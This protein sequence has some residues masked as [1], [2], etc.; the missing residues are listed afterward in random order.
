M[1]RSFG[2]NQQSTVVVVEVVLANCIEINGIVTNINQHFHF[3][4]PICTNHEIFENAMPLPVNQ[5]K[6]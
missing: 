4:G 6:L 1:C 3:L 5:N 2:S